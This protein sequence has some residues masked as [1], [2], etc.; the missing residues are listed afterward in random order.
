MRLVRA[1]PEL[2]EQA[3]ETVEKWLAAGNS[4]STG[5]WREWEV[6]LRDRTWR[7]VLSRTRREQQLRQ[8]S[9]LVTLLPD[10]VRRHVLAQMRE[11]KKGVTLGGAGPSEPA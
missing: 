9:P 5:L 4:R 8:A 7:K 10:A 2:V 3:R 6:I 11:L 1:N